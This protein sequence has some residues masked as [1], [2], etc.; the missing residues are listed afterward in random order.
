MSAGGTAVLVNRS[1]V[2]LAP[3]FA[4]AV[5][6]SIE[7]CHANGLDA[8][9]FETLRSNA[10]AAVYYARGRPPSHE[11]PEPVTNA[12]DASWSWHG[13]GLAV[14]VIS[15]SK[16][17]DAG[18]AWFTQVAAIFATHGCDWGGT[19]KHPD[20]PHFQ[21]GRCRPS[22][23][24]ISRRLHAEGHIQDVWRLVRAA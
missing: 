20:R 21:W 24:I 11:Y 22:P 3:L 15:A 8:F 19:W 17:W 4:R 18:D 7:E 6:A 5:V 14:D 12:P 23:S 1:F 16:E 9:V 10:L 2:G 13:Y